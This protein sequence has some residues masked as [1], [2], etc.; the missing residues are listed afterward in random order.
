[1]RKYPDDFPSDIPH[2]LKP[3]KE[4]A[5]VL[6]TQAEFLLSINHYKKCYEMTSRYEMK[7]II[8]LFSI[9][10]NDPLNPECLPVHISILKML[11]K[12]NGR[13]LVI[14]ALNITF[15]TSSCS[16]TSW[17]NSIQSRL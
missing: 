1:M 4:S 17:P 6:L 16:Q 9:L 2:D 3:L 14:G 11:D 13:Y 12:V 15:Q 7:L 10:Q 8:H 5:E